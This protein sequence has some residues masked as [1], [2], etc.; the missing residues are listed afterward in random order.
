MPQ[1]QILRLNRNALSDEGVRS[2]AN[3]LSRGLLPRLQDISLAGNNIGDEGAE[4]LTEAVRGGGAAD[5]KTLVL[6]DNAL[7]AAA[8]V[9]LRAVC[10]VRK[11]TLVL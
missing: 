6:N 7:G 5:L 4:A 3:A 9:E 2:L 1:L 10:E 8:K 11:V